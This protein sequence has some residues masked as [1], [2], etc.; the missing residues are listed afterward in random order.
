[1]PPKD[2]SQKFFIKYQNA[3]FA[4]GGGP[5]DFSFDD[6][7]FKAS[8]LTTKPDTKI[9]T[10][11]LMAKLRRKRLRE[12]TA[13]KFFHEETSSD[14]ETEEHQSIRLSVRYF[15]SNLIVA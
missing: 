4:E 8:V 15:H 12:M 5:N 3:S 7:D 10:P 2:L 6:D 13:E 9:M 14:G 1:M 11:D